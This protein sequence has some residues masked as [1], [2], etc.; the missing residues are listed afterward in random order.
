MEQQVC[1]LLLVSKWL[2]PFS[3]LQVLQRQFLPEQILKLLSQPEHRLQQRI[4]FC[5]ALLMNFLILGW[6]FKY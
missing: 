4:C 5:Q 1:L 6:F 3:L 2:V